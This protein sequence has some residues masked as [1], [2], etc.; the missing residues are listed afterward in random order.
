MFFTRSKRVNASYAV[1]DRIRALGERHA[2]MRM[3]K[4]GLDV[5]YVRE[6]EPVFLAGYVFPSCLPCK[7]TPD[8]SVT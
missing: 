4:G 1:D 3:N 8:Y 5:G 6:V 7:L 2:M